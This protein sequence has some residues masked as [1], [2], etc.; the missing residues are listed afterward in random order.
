MGRTISW[1]IQLPT[2]H[3]Y[4]HNH[5]YTGGSLICTPPAHIALQPCSSWQL[6]DTPFIRNAFIALH[7]GTL[8]FYFYVVWSFQW[9]NFTTLTTIPTGPLLVTVDSFFLLCCTCFK[10]IIH[11]RFKWWETYVIFFEKGFSQIKLILDL[12][13]KVE[14]IVKIFRIEAYVTMAELYR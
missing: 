3:D 6:I 14:L 12:W 10:I 2:Y 8:C 7:R 13:A 11:F 5:A 1:L 4:T 9:W